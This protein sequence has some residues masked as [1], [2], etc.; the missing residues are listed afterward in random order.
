MQW[1]MWTFFLSPT[2]I[3]SRPQTPNKTRISN[4]IS[5]IATPFVL[6]RKDE[7]IPHVSQAFP[8]YA[9]LELLLFASPYSYHSLRIMPHSVSVSA[10]F[11][12][13]TWNYQTPTRRY[14]QTYKY[15]VAKEKEGV[16]SLVRLH[17]LRVNQG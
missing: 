3:L 2:L 12:R 8:P 15:G 11:S 16:V 1:M 10:R 9:A 7:I 17:S 4:R 13:S 5:K 14:G 6:E